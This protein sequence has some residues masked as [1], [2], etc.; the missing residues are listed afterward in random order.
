M[1][2][3]PQNLAKTDKLDDLFDKIKNEF[4]ALESF[5]EKNEEKSDRFRMYVKSLYDF[6]KIQDDNDY[7][8]FSSNKKIPTPSQPSALPELIIDKNLVDLEQIYQQLQLYNQNS[9]LTSSASINSLTKFFSKCLAQPEPMSFSIDTDPSSIGKNH[10]ASSLSNEDSG[11]AEA[12]QED[13]DEY[14]EDT[15]SIDQLINFTKAQLDEEEQKAG[16]PDGD[17]SEIEDFD[18]DQNEDDEGGE[19]NNEDMDSD[20]VD[21]DL[22]EMYGD[23]DAE[24]EKEMLGIGRPQKAFDEIDFD[25]EDFGLA[26]PKK[27]KDLFAD[28]DDQELDQN[29]SSFEKRNEKL[30]EQIEEIHD[31]MLTNLTDKP[32]QLKG[33]VNAKGRPQDSLLE[34]YVEF[35]HTTRQAPV[36]D[37]STTEQ[38]EK[39]IKQRIKDKAFDDVERKVKPVDMQYEY[40][41]QVVLDSEKS[42]VGLGDVY[43]QEYVKQQQKELGDQEERPK[44]EAVNPKH[45][46]IRKKMQELFIKLDALSNFHFTPKAPV[47]ELKVVSNMP[48]IAMEEVAPVN[49]ADTDVLAPEE[50]KT[51]IKALP[52]SKSEENKS[53]KNRNMRVKKLISKKRKVEKEKRLELAQALDPNNEKISKEIA[54]NKLKKQAKNLSK[55]IKILKQLQENQDLGKSKVIKKKLD[56]SGEAK[57]S[58]KFKL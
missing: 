25:R 44:E 40:K 11:E 24:Q 28:Q 4:D 36:M 32:W 2:A 38:I 16:I 19:E 45:E 7:I 26:E 6:I 29:K 18:V 46:E 17:D 49:V 30:K 58:K 47:P 39:M 35:D 3:L 53:D 42:K 37:A 54:M 14:D 1:V 22:T 8:T 52:K 27:T 50:V 15:D 57:S 23:M 55:N 10:S 48:T 12:D 33:E 13:E 34:E 9:D 51:S 31:T 5:L 43:A 41:K 21:E 20:E 56:K